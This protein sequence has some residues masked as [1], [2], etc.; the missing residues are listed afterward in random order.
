ME[1]AFNK[2]HYWMVLLF[3]I[4]EISIFSACTLPDQTLQVNQP[5][6]MIRKDG[7][8]DFV[9][10]DESITASIAIEIADTPETQMKGLMGRSALDDSS[11]M[12]FVFERSEPRKFWM[13]NT[14]I[15]LDIIFIGADGC[16]VNI[17]ESTPPM[18]N[19]RYRSKGAIKY[20]VE[21]CAGF[22]KRFKIDSST[23]IRWQRL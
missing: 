7:I 8:L 22:V 17:V 4:L 1:S 2:Q 3:F 6:S 9:Y 18:S 12:L 20:V 21:V 15:P 16:I 10:P 19:Q 5:P 23:C 11:G 13:K 14:P